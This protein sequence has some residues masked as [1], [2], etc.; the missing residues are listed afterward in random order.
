MLDLISQVSFNNAAVKIFEKNKR[1]GGRPTH[2]VTREPVPKLYQCSPQ[3][4]TS[5]DF[6][7]TFSTIFICNLKIYHRKAT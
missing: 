6:Y 2:E 5:Q 3:V 1:L 7:N 4:H